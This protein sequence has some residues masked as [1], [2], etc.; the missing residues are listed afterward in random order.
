MAELTL[1][2]AADQ[3]TLLEQ[4][5]FLAGGG[6]SELGA[7]LAAHSTAGLF[8]T[9]RVSGAIHNYDLTEV[10]LDADTL[11]LFKGGQPVADTYYFVADD[12]KAGG[13]RE[14]GR[15][16]NAAA[17]PIHIIGCNLRQHHYAHWMMQCLPAIDWSIRHYGRDNVCLVLRELEP[18]QE[19]TLALLGLASLPRL[20]PQAGRQ[21][22]LPHAVYSEFINGAAAY[23]VSLR[24]AATARRLG[25][26]I[27]P[28]PSSYPMIYVPSSAP[29]CGWISNEAEIIDCLVNHGFHIFAPDSLTIL[30]RVNL[31]R[32]ADLVIGPHADD[33]AD[34]MFCKPGAMLWEL[35]DV[36]T[37]TPASIAS[38][39]PPV[40]IIGASCLASRTKAVRGSGP[41][42][43][44]S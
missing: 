27:A 41:W 4:S 23:H 8:R 30:D 7:A 34:C 26:A 2:D 40:S 24:L 38:L 6:M 33:L 1:K 21:Y 19:D 35:I 12:G 3:V 44:V 22:R 31:F 37:K 15:L 20:V 42:M 10:V 11:I 18:W 36:I 32:H 16:A 28:E 5:A 25:E 43:S 29:F 14:V 17:A 9:I 13:A 39:K